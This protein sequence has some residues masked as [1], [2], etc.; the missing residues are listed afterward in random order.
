MAVFKV[1]WCYRLDM[2]GHGQRHGRI[3]ALRVSYR[4]F[5]AGSQNCRQKLINH[6]QDLWAESFT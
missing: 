4:A 6:R 2:D 3:E 1:F 5:R